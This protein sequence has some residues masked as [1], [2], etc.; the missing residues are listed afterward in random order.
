[1]CL[2]W[3]RGKKKDVK[4]NDLISHLKEVE[5]EAIKP[6]LNKRKEV[7]KTRAE[8]HAKKTKMEK[9]SKVESHL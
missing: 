7:M 4:L 9:I 2:Y 8:I 5:R 3:K 1:M 6:K